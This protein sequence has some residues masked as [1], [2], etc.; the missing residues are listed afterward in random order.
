M[1]NRINMRKT[2]TV[3]Q[4]AVPPFIMI[5]RQGSGTILLS[6]PEILSWPGLKATRAYVLG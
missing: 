1:T 4:C 5:N 2:N 6:V 3:D